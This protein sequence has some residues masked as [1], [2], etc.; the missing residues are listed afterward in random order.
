MEINL[1]LVHDFSFVK[2]KSE[3]VRSNVKLWDQ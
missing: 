2:S 3:I 1:L